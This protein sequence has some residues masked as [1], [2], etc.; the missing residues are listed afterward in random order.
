MV[1]NHSWILEIASPEP[2]FHSQKR[3]N[4]MGKIRQRW[5]M[6]STAMFSTVKNCCIHK[7]VCA[8]ACAESTN[9]GPS[10]IPDIATDL[11]PL[12]TYQ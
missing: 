2:W 9:P 12:N 10:I 5:R 8:K 4:H 7:T 1:M 6:G 11:L 3:E